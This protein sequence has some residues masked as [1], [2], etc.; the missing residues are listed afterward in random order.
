M[1]QRWHDERQMSRVEQ[2]GQFFGLDVGDDLVE[3][4]YAL[5]VDLLFVL[6]VERFQLGED[7]SDVVNELFFIC[8]GQS[9]QSF[10]GLCFEDGG[11]L[12]ETFYQ[13]FVIVG[14]KCRH[15]YLL[16]FITSAPIK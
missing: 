1:A 6:F 16:L 4:Q 5:Q 7:W 9:V 14:I 13:K 10:E 12:A 3:Q 2:V 11:T 8:S 15:P